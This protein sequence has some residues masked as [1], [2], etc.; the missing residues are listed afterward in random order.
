L[1]RKEITAVTDHRFLSAQLGDSERNPKNP[2]REILM[3]IWP[4]SRLRSPK[5]KTNSKLDFRPKPGK[6]FPA[7]AKM[8]KPLIPHG[9]KS[10]AREE[11]RTPD[12]MLGKRKKHRRK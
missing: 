3:T 12:L 10:G 5:V 7:P 11:G 1:L 4:W 2:L 6:L 8:K 9:L